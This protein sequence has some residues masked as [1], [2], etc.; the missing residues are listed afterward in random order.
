[1]D[2]EKK[3][4]VEKMNEEKIAEAPTSENKTEK[5]KEVKVEEKKSKKPE[6][7]II[8]KDNAIAKGLGVHMSM[9]QGKYICK[10]VKNKK[11]DVAIADLVSVTK[12]KKAVPYK[13]EIPHRKGK[14]MMSG[15][16]PVK[17]AGQFIKILK[18]LK[19]NALASGLDVDNSVIHHAS[20][21]WASRPSKRG[22]KKAKRA[23]IVV[24]VKEIQGAKNG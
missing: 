20:A 4:E 24:M 7:M 6:K 21:S 19:G 17:A 2:N 13:G 15:R 3:Q 9:K 5:K 23:N 10:F 22:G 11:V 1:M 16:Y 8:K 12:M 14:G 18:G